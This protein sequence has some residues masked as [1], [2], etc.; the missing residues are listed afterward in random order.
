MLVARSFTDCYVCVREFQSGALIFTT[1]VGTAFAPIIGCRLVLN[2]R[3]AYY[4]PFSTEF[5]QQEFD[6]NFLAT[7][8][9]EGHHIDYSDSSL[10]SGRTSL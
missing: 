10:E 7:D 5:E 9:D 4:H 3:D 6:L 8:S 2:L 1:M